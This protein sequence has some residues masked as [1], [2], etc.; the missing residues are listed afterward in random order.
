M[1]SGHF[2]PTKFFLRSQDSAEWENS[3]WDIWFTNLFNTW[4]TGFGV[5]VNSTESYKYSKNTSKLHFDFKSP[6]MNPSGVRVNQVV[7][8]NSI[9][10]FNSSNNT[11]KMVALSLNHPAVAHQIFSVSLSTTKRYTTYAQVASEIN[12]QVAAIN[13]NFS[14]SVEDGKLKLQ[15]TSSAT[16]TLAVTEGNQRFGFDYPPIRMPGEYF[17]YAPSPIVLQPTRVVYIKS[18]SFGITSSY[19]SNDA[20]NII[21]QIPMRDTL[22]DY[23]GSIVYTNPNPQTLINLNPS[24]VYP[25]LDFELL[26]DNFN[27]IDLRRHNWS[28][29]MSFTY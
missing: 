21:A 25:H 14:C 16:H 24:N 8:P 18:D 27:Q 6:L 7:L 15:S 5:T 20:H 2:Q 3:A 23:G 11:L 9:P 1:D 19:C 13:A 12:T 28:I 17:V 26:D 4:L 10:T 29:E 22:V